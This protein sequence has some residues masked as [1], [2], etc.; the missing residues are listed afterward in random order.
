MRGEMEPLLVLTGAPPT[1]MEEGRRACEDGGG[2]R[3]AAGCEE[4]ELALAVALVL[5]GAILASVDREPRTRE[6]E[7]VRRTAGPEVTRGRSANGS[8]GEGVGE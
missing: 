8:G 3:A 5:S 4:E 6:P 2:A 7:P 1:M